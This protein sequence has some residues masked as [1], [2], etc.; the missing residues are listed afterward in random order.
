MEEI[1]AHALQRQAFDR[2]LSETPS[3]LA[4]YLRTYFNHFHAG[5]GSHAE[6][7]IIAICQIAARHG[8]FQVFPTAPGKPEIGDNVTGN[9]I[10]GQTIHIALDPVELPMRW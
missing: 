5:K 4:V 9:S 3:N 8:Y 1:I 6:F 7:R 2:Y 10:I